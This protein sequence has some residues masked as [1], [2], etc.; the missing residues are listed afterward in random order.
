MVLLPIEIQATLCGFQVTHKPTLLL[1]RSCHHRQTSTGAT[2]ILKPPD[3]NK[4]GTAAH[5]DTCDTLWA[6]GDAQID[7]LFPA[8]LPSPADIHRARNGIKKS[9]QS[10]RFC[11]PSR[12][13]RLSVGFR[14][15]TNPYSLLPPSSQHRQTSTGAARVFK[16]INSNKGTAAY[17]DKCDTLWASGDTQTHNLA[18]A[19]LPHCSI[20]AR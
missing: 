2:R 4:E 18:P 19:E 8:E 9:Q 12:Y 13:M 11:C 1:S 5:R 3:S 15:R 6:S 7:T 14:R 10:Q 20:A 17:R 16:I